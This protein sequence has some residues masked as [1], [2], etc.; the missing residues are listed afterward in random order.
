M[1]IHGYLNRNLGWVGIHDLSRSQF[2]FIV[3]T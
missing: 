1:V 3:I 2:F